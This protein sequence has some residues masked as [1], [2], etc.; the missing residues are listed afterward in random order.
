MA[1]TSFIPSGW[2][3]RLTEIAET[4][5]QLYATA[6]IYNEDVCDISPEV[7][8]VAKSRVDFVCPSHRSDEIS[9]FFTRELAC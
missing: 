8:A 6:L 4:A 5:P 3:A 9:D 2:S 1:I 7:L